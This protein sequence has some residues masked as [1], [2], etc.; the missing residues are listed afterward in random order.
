MNK[1]WEDAMVYAIWRLGIL[2]LYDVKVMFSI[3][4]TRRMYDH[5]E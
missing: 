5:W 1:Y 3:I 2:D 4:A